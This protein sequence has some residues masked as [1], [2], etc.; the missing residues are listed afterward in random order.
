MDQERVLR[1]IDVRQEGATGRRPV[2]ERG[3]CDDSD[4]ILKRGRH[5]KYEPEGIRRRPAAVR[6]ADRGHEMRAFAVGNQLL[7]APDH[8][9][10]GCWCLAS[11]CRRL[12]ARG[13][14]GSQGQATGQGGAVLEEFPSI[15]S[16]RTHRPLLRRCRTPS[17]K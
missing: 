4:G 15:K 12:A 7:V 2:V 17:G 10:S 16:F 13:R 14:Y 5:M 3:R 6:Y 8:L 9:R 11:G 1:G